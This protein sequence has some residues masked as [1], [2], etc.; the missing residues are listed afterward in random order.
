[1][2]V[3]PAGTTR[4]ADPLTPPAATAPAGPEDLEDGRPRP[5]APDVGPVPGSGIS[6][7]PA[8]IPSTVNPVRMGERDPKAPPTIDGLAGAGLVGTGLVGL[9]G[10][11]LVGTG[12]AA[13]VEE[14][15][16]AAQA[17]NTRRGYAADWTH[18]TGW[19]ARYRLDPLPADPADVAGYVADLARLRRANGRWAYTPATLARRVAGINFV[20]RRAGHLPPGSAEVVRATLAGLRRTR[21]TPP[22]RMHALPLTTLLRALNQIETRRWPGAVTGRRDRAM[23][24]LGWSS[25]LRRAELAALRREDLTAHPQDGLHL[26]IRTSKTDPDAH[27]ATLAVPFGTTPATCAACALTQWVQILDAWDGHTYTR[28]GLVGRAAVL[29]LMLTE[30]PPDD[31]GGHVCHHP[32]NTTHAANSADIAVTG[33]SRPSVGEEVW[34]Q[35]PLLR[36]VSKAATIAG[37]ALAGDAV[38]AVLRRRLAAAGVN[39]DGYGAHSLRA[40][41]VTDAYRAGASTHAISRQTRHRDPATVEGY[42]RHYTPLEANAVTQVGL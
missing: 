23:L 14:L 29:R 25:A 34:G 6:S 13:A 7:A 30:P 40:G 42:A 27:G 36:P 3:E 19:A 17:P 41:F 11:G 37:R 16:R 20:H 21:A 31:N 15:A 10:T 18:F 28:D 22:R 26:L 9:V 4:D 1:M 38:H 8:G 2:D 32:T 24:L 5:A 33:R 39:P 12:L 35:G